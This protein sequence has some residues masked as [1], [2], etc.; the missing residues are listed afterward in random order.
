MAC[1]HAEAR[2]RARPAA[3][4]RRRSAFVVA[5]LALGLL[6]AALLLELGARAAGDVFELHLTFDPGTEEWARFDPRLGWVNLPGRL[7]NNRQGFRFP[8]DY[9]GPANAARVVLVGDSQVWG[10]GVGDDEHLGV[11]LD[12]ELPDAEVY[13]FGVPGYG[14]V[15]ELLLLRDVLRDYEVD[16]VFAVAFV[17]ND[18][19]D[20]SVS[21]AYGGLQKPY[22]QRDEE[23]WT[24]GN[25]PVPRP[26]LP[27][28]SDAG[29]MPFFGRDSELVFLVPHATLERWSALYRLTLQRAS[30]GPWLAQALARVGLTTLVTERPTAN[31]L[32]SI[33][34]IDGQPV[35]CWHLDSCPREHRLDGL[36]AVTRAYVAMHRSCAERDVAFSVVV[37]PSY[38]ELAQGHFDVTDALADRLA[39][40]GVPVVDLRE[41]FRREPDWHGIVGPDRHWT[42][43]GHRRVADALRA[44]LGDGSFARRHPGAK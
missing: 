15:Q 29:S 10:M 36:A 22:L 8:R 25:Q 14:P 35:P 9:V 7:G 13:P 39:T 27:G 24:L 11:L 38:V 32:Y 43:R 34:R 6:V 44:A 12:R 16:A 37:T 41:A 30:R 5:A 23:G 26:V 3:G 17:Y 33:R 19:V 20:E 2:G 18:L 40:E 31:E 1:N 4:A 42:A 28:G 21:I